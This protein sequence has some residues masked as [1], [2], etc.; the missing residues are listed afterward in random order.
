M[1]VFNNL[2]IRTFQY[3]LIS[4]PFLHAFAYNKFTPL[5]LLFSVISFFII[6][7]KNKF[8]LT[9]K[10]ED[11]FLL[12]TF[13][14]GVIMNVI[15]SSQIGVKNIS[16]IS[17]W[18]MTIFFLY[19]WTSSWL[20]R[21]KLSY[22][23]L[24]K[25]STHS[26]II[27]SLGVLFDFILANSYGFYLSDLIPYSFDQME[28]TESL[29]GSR[30]RGF[31]AEPGFSAVVFEMFLPLSYLYLKNFKKRK[32]IIYFFSILC[33]LLLTS[34]ASIASILASYVLVKI[35]FS[36]RKDFILKLSIPFFLVFLSINYYTSLNS[37]FQIFEAI[38]GIKFDRF[39]SG[40]DLRAKILISLISIWKLNPLG[41]G[42]GA[43][44][45]SFQLGA[46]SIDSITL[47]GAGAL[48]LYLEI[49][50]SCGIIGLLS[51]IIFLSYKIKNIIKLKNKTLKKV[52]LLALFSVLFHHFFIS[53]IWFPMI[54]VL[55]ALTNNFKS[56][57]NAENERTNSKKSI[58]SS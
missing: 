46:K 14:M 22:Y 30:P 16:H 38:I 55:L 34:A 26:L 37:D 48:N 8:F 58:I 17:A 43:I 2:K 47:Y 3:F 33:Y 45:Q 6:G 54:W 44:S 49:L 10:K 52:F 51:F 39:L 36:K 24:G 25:F 1:L 29:L 18:G 50:V 19:F 31:S 56:L 28:K 21:I 13:L 53:E 23:L 12:I 15:Y 7:L 41:L 20:N 27:V 32:Y 40:E 5:P 35:I 57:V 11:I 4:I 42:F 9:F